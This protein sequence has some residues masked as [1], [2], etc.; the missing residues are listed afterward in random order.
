[1]RQIGL[2]LTIN[3][4]RFTLQIPHEL[5]AELFGLL[6]IPVNPGRYTL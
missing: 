3:C 1:M 4:G 5:L 2:E 6:E